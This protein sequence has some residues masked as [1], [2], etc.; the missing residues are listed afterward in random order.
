MINLTQKYQEFLDMGDPRV[1]SWPLMDS[2][3]KGITLVVMYLSFVKVI[4]PAWM[5]DQKPYDLRYPMV[6]YNFALVAVSGWLFINFGMLG[7]FT[8]YSWRCEPIDYSNSPDAVKMAEI[9]WY[10]Y[11]TKFIEFADTIFFVLRKK[12][13]QISS[14]HV[15][16]HSLVPLTLWFGIKYAPGGYNSIFA[17]INSFV[18]TWMYLYYGLAALGPAY[19]KFL[20]WKKYMTI[21]QMVQ[22]LLVF[23]FMFQLTFFPTCEVSKPMLALN[24]VQA[25][26]FFVLFLNFFSASYKKRQ[27]K[28]REEKQTVVNDSTRS[29][30]NDCCEKCEQ[31]R[32][33]KPSVQKLR[34]VDV[35]YVTEAVTISA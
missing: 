23:S 4:G 5:R 3:M 26:I 35:N 33:R 10:F 2:P 30:K 19:Q 15:F 21:L 8:H 31:I 1:A 7:W 16:H 12:D 25:I 29:S 20:W 17:F 28:K 11:V 6:I 24:V 27:Q 32:H 18:H 34:Y 14:L 9:G 22:F 13:S